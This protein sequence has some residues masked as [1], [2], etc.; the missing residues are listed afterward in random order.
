MKKKSFETWTLA[1]ALA[2]LLCACLAMVFGWLP[3]S[4]SQRK[5]VWGG[6]PTNAMD[7]ARNADTSNLDTV[8]KF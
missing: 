4:E 3:G 7:A 1:G 2:A 6:R 8:L 5:F